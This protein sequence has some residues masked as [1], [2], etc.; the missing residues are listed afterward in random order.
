MKL[1]RYATTK[2]GHNAKQTQ[3]D[4]DDHGPDALRYFFNEY[5]VLGRNESLADLYT[6][7]RNGTEAD[8]FFKLNSGI[9]REYDTTRW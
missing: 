9:S 2:E 1:L 8:T 3:H 5:F 4:Y 7:V 6:G